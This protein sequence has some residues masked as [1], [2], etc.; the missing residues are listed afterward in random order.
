MKAADHQQAD[1]PFGVATVGLHPI[2][3]GAL[4]LARRRDDA[5]D[6]ALLERPGQA[7]A[8]RTRLVGDPHRRRQ[9]GAEVGH[10]LGRPA[11]LPHRQLAGLRVRDRRHDLHGVNIQTNPRP[12]LRHVGTP[13]IAVLAEAVPRRRTRASHARVPT[14]TRPP[15]RAVLRSGGHRV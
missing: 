9:S 2:G 14:F 5:G 8:G 10:L 1:Q 15:D 12:N 11:Q 6:P 7:E 4:D 3:G 13:M